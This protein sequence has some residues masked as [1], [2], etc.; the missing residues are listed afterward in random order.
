MGR[1]DSFIFPNPL[2]QVIDQENR[3]LIKEV[4]IEELGELSGLLLRT[5]PLDGMVFPLFSL[6][7]S[8]PLSRLRWP[9]R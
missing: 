1:G 2:S 3:K 6:E 5:K 4:S 8:S 7:D 9:R